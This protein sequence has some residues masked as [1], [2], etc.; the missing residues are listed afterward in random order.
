MWLSGRVYT[1]HV[2]GLVLKFQHIQNI[3]IKINDK[4]GEISLGEIL[5]EEKF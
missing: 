2:G 1:L 4:G 3:L 5:L